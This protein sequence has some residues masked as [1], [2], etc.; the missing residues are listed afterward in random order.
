MRIAITIEF[1][2][3]IGVCVEVHDRDV[4]V[5]VR[6]RLHEGPGHEMVTAECQQLRAVCDRVA[7][8]ATDQRR[9]LVHIVGERQVTQIS[10]VSIHVGGEI[11]PILRAPVGRSTVQRSTHSRWGRSRTPEI[12]R[13]HVVGH[14]EDLDTHT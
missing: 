1:V 12:G 13:V 4:V 11:A 8:G 6:H 5:A 2:V 7:C 10:P 14:T 3:E 9:R